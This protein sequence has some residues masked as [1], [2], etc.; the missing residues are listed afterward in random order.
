[1]AARSQAAQRYRLRP[2]PRRAARGRKSRIHWD[3]LGRVIL[4]LVVFGILVSYVNPLMNFVDAWRDSGTERTQLHDLQRENA[5]LREHEQIAQ[6]SD[7]KQRAAR[8][9]GMIV[10]GERSYVIRGLG[11]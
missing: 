7:S 6:T 1:M 9:L 10:P 8:K 3:K 4:V 2:A 5:R 11:N